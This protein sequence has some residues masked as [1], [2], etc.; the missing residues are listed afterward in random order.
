MGF[1]SSAAPLVTSDT[2]ITL[3]IARNKDGA[4]EVA[5]LPRGVKFNENET[6]RGI[7][8][9][10]AALSKPFRLVVP[11]NDDPDEAFRVAVL[12]LVKSREPLLDQMKTYHAE[13]EAAAEAARQ[14]R[15]ESQKKNAAK[16]ATKAAGAKAEKVAQR[17][18]PAGTDADDADE[19][20]GKAPA[21]LDG[22]GTGE[23]A[24]AAAD[25]PATAQLF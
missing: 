10:Q 12:H 25:G 14:A 2:E 5:V 20:A 3:R 11:A 9:L 17:T 21:R 15:L 6:D 22:A 24:Q 1:L 4:L 8:L 7:A 18:A 13:N 16:P 19:A 23:C